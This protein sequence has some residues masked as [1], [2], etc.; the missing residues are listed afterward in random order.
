MSPKIVFVTDM[1]DAAV[2][3][4]EMAP[5]GFEL[6]VAAAKSAEYKAAM[7]DAEYLVG[8]VDKLVDAELYETAP[9]LKLIQLL[10]AGYDKADLAAA[11]KA[12]SC[13]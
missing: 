3:G 10:S 8:F 11:R 9:K 7:R 4:R 12:A 2:V 6:I 1:P 13:C 5:A